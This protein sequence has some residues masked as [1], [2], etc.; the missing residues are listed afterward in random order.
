MSL[1][2]IHIQVHQIARNFRDRWIPRPM[3]RPNFADRDDGKIEFHRSSNG[4]RFSVS[5][6]NLRDQGGRPTEAIDCIKQ[7]TLG[8]TMGDAGVQEGGSAPCASVSSSSGTKTRKRKSRW[9]QP[10]E[11]K[12]QK[13][14]PGSIKQFE[15][16]SLPGIS[17]VAADVQNHCQLNGASV[18][19]DGSEIVLEDAPPGFSSSHKTTLVSSVSSSMAYHSKCSHTIIG[20]PQEKFVSRLPVSYGI[21]LSIMQQFGSPHAENVGSRVVAPGMPFSPFPP[22]P[23]FPRDKK[24]HSPSQIVNPMTVNEPAA[25]A[26]Q[27]E[28]CLPATSHSNE[29]SPRTTS[30][31]PDLEVPF[32]DNQH[33]AKRGRGSSCDLSR[34]YFKQQ[35]WNNTKSGLPPWILNR[36]GGVE[37]PRVGTSN[38]GV[39]KVTNE[40]RNTHCSED[41]SC[42]AEKDGNNFYQ[43][44]E[45]HNQ[46]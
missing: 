31:R 29:N 4:Y 26:A 45:Q 3:R 21:P 36:L 19:H 16:S 18:A 22:L 10:A 15:S 42:K 20:L 6:N 5:H 11:P 23:P 25:E 30:D 35:K 8:T 44:S 28:G 38:I 33:S 1:I 24:D 37:N 12:E 32:T 40:L 13:I 2:N 43:N 34:R 39:G 27:P 14:E 9:D 7:S 46:H 17:Q 41:L